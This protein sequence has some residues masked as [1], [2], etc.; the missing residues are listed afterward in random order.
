MKIVNTTYINVI[1]VC[2]SSINVECSLQ[3][4]TASRRCMLKAS[5]CKS[6]ANRR[7][8]VS[9]TSSASGRA[10]DVSVSR[11]VDD[12]YPRVVSLIICIVY[13]WGKM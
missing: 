1:F 12:R 6:V 9:A 3:R 2:I 10:N 7:I 8:A 4:R 13:V 11:A 5:T